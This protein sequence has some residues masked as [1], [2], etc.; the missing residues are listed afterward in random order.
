MKAF[1]LGLVEAEDGSNA[2]KSRKR[3]LGEK[4]LFFV[5]LAILGGGNE[6][7]VGLRQVADTHGVSSA[8]MSRYFAHVCMRCYAALKRETDLLR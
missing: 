6:G 1:D 8:T 7:G 3:L 5:F 4:E 2:K